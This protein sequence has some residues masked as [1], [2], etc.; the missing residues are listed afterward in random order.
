MVG[1]LWCVVDV[2]GTVAV[3]AVV[4]V[5][6]GTPDMGNNLGVVGL[7]PVGVSGHHGPCPALSGKPVVVCP[8]HG[9]CV[10]MVGHV[11]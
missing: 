8:C 5:A 10:S 2:A 1:L 11:G 9:P 3:A 6:A 7:M 4:D